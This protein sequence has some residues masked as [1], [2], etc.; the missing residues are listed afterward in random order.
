MFSTPNYFNWAF[1]AITNL[2][3]ANTSLFVSMGQ[4]LFRALATIMIA[5]FGIKT[6]LSSGDHWGGIH[7]SQFA[8]L[9]LNISFGFAMINYYAT[10]IPGVGTDFHH[11]VTDQAQS[12]SNTLSQ[13]MLDTVVNR[14]SAFEGTV[15]SPGTTM[16]VAVYFD[17]WTIIILLAIAQAV[18]MVVIAFGIIAMAVCVLLGP[19]FIPFFIVPQL[20]WLF[21]GWFKCFIQYSFYQVVA[22]A[23]VYIIGNILTSFLTFYNGQPMTIDRQG[24]LIAPLF[25]V[26]IASV[27]ALLKVPVLTSHIF[28]GAAGLS[29][30]GIAERA[31]K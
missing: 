4:N 20:D 19:V 13:N 6:A 11:L 22:A 1:Q 23:V 29:S 8:S 2:L 24:A 9:V 26:T 28:S 17:Y 18:A 31:F 16:Q 25:I 15:E 27:Y 7:M 12:L 5:W 14:I 30:S 3:N 10:P 21:W